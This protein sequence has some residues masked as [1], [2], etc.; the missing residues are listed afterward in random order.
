VRE[1]GVQSR[2]VRAGRVEAGRRHAP[3]PPPRGDFWQALAIVAV[4]VATA[5]WTTVAVLALRDTSVA[6]AS[7]SDT[8]EP[9]P[10]DE[11][12]VPP[13][14]DTHDAPEMEALLP[15]ELSGTAL[16]F[17]S[18]TGDEIL[19]DDAFG[20]SLSTFLASAGKTAVDLR[21]AQAVDP[22]QA[23]DSRIGVYRVAGVEAN[24]LRDALIAAWKVDR[25][26]IVVSQVTLGGT[27]VTKV[28]FGVDYPASYLYLQGDLVYDIG[29]S[30]EAI[31]TATL[32]ALPG[33][34]SSPSGAPGSPAPSGSVTPSPSSN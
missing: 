27:D 26:E 31:A 23:L 18:W 7:P 13:V 14:A 2:R 5:G 28:D 16:Q 3:P 32:A 25:P 1:R 15:L 17:Q 4:V 30:D 29:T 22:T 11:P 10:T 8:I 33:P 6:V 12:S 20:T 9:E 19:A 21:I 24:A 34:R